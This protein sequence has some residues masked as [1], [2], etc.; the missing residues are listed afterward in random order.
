MVFIIL[1]PKILCFKRRFTKVRQSFLKTSAPKVKVE[2]LNSA[3]HKLIRGVFGSGPV[4]RESYLVWGEGGERVGDSVT[5]PSLPHLATMLRYQ[6][7][8]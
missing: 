4:I 6:K 8:L 1:V 2:K 5:P 3:K 7:L